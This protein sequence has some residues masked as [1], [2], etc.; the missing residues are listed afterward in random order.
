MD[1]LLFEGEDG[2]EEEEGLGLGLVEEM[3]PLKG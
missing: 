1:L 2:V 3:G